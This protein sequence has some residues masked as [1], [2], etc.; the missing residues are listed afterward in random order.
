MSISDWCSH[1]CSSDLFAIMSQLC[2]LALVASCS[3]KEPKLKEYN[4]I[5]ACFQAMDYQY[6]A[7]LTKADIAKHVTIDDASYKLEISPTK[8]TYAPCVY[9]WDSARSNDRRVV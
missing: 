5:S 2:I 6:D 7:L 9:T 8:G 1:V 3:D 4:S